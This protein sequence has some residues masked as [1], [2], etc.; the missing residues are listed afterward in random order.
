MRTEA[1][2]FAAGTVVNALATLKGVAFGIKLE[3]RVVFREEDELK[4]F[5]VLQDGRMERSAIAEKLMRNSGVEGGVFEVESEIP[6]R[7]GLGSSS[8]FMNAMIMA[9]MK[10]MEMPLNA[11][12]ILRINARISLES[13]MSYTGAFDDASASLLGGLVFSDNS[14]MRLY[15]RDELEGKVVILLPKWE[16]GEVNLREIRRGREEVDRA[17]RLAMRGELKAAMY[18]NSMHYCT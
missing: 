1:K 8:A 4:G 16:R 6:R 12:K 14:R 5:Y 18:L 13:G 11:E 9:A 3:T 7:S 10:A 17:F 2:S 15:R